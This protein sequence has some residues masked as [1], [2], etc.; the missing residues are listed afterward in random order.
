MK[1]AIGINNNIYSIV[2]DKLPCFVETPH[3]NPLLAEREHSP[4]T[5][6]G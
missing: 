1:S 4:Q 2:M 3:P 5:T 6:R